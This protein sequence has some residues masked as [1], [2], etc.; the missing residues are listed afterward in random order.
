MK[1]LAPASTQARIARAWKR[2]NSGSS[3]AIRLAS[4]R[5]VRTVLSP[6][7]SAMHWLA[8]RVACPTFSPRSQRK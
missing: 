4:S 7:A 8:E 2:A 6:A 3:P 5:V 1:P